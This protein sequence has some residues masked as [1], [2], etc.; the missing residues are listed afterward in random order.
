MT[1]TPIEEL[2]E[3]EPYIEAE[4]SGDDDGPPPD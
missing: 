1:G 3:L 4:L 2:L